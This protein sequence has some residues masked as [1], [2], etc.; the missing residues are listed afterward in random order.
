MGLKIAA[1]DPKKKTYPI[2]T[3][4]ELACDEDHGFLDA[5]SQKFTK[6]GFIEQFSKAMDVG[7]KE[8]IHQ[9]RG[10][11]FICPGCSGK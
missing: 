8:K 5:P 1:I 7:W 3:Y 6:G 10:R 9:S 4:L 11:I 2:G